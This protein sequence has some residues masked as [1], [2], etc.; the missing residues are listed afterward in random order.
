MFFVYPG[1]HPCSLSYKL[2]SAP[3]KLNMNFVRAT[4][5][6][7]CLLLTVMIALLLCISLHKHQSDCKARI[8]QAQ[9]LQKLMFMDTSDGA[10]YVTRCGHDWLNLFSRW[11][12]VQRRALDGCK[13]T[14]VVVWKCDGSCGGLGDRQRGILTSFMLAL[15]TGRAFFI[16]SEAPVPL[17]RFFHVANPSL[18]WHFEQS[19]LD[20]RSVLHEDFMNTW[21]PIGDYASSNLSHYDSHDVVIQ[22]NNFWQPFHIL[23]N[24]LLPGWAKKLRHYDDHILAGCLLNYLLVPAREVQMTLEQVRNTVAAQ[25]DRLLAVQIRTGDSQNKN[26]TVLTEFIQLF[27]TCVQNL[28]R[29]SQTPFQIFL[30]TDSDEALVA[31]KAA[32]PRLLF[33]AGDIF[34][35]DGAFGAPVDADAAFRK[36]VLD[37]VMIS[38]ASDL[39]ISRSGFAEY[40]AVRG[41]KSYYTPV[42]CNAG[43]P[44]PHF[45]MPTSEPAGVS[46]ADIHS[47]EE[48]VNRPG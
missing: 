16:Q 43:K 39:L 37:H 12:R 22:A 5:L 38:Q 2:Q 48:M 28:E 3:S 34:H 13:E 26:G 14:K 8:S 36:L 19:H 1:S 30:T 40:A 41:F 45:S 21:P 46:A 20:G 23:R 15:V 27:K 31:F 33:F 44:V 32:Y 25:S 9:Q 4:K 47:V 29:F 24:P 17:R 7:T 6:K 35:V 42:N 18:H 10:E 11:E